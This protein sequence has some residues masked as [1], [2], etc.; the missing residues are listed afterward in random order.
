VC[1]QVNVACGESSLNIYGLVQKLWG[2]YIAVV[3]IPAY[4]TSRVRN[5]GGS[6]AK[7]EDGRMTMKVWVAVFACAAMLAIAGAAFADAITDEYSMLMKPA[8]AANVALQ[9]AIM[10]GDMATAASK[11]GEVQSDFAKIE[12]FWAKTNT[13]D[14]V[15]FAKA[16]QA[17]AKDVQTAASAGNKDAAAAAAMKIGGSCGGCHMAHRMRN[18]DGT[19]QLKP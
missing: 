14:A 2:Q 16:V 4:V 17:A 19:F 1:E 3:S 12:Q 18:P 15:N 8:G 9:K 13:M 7:R 6:M 5:N 11:A 10:D